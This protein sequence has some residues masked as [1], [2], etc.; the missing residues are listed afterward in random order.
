MEQNKLCNAVKHIARAYLF[1]HIH[2]NL[3]TVDILPD[4]LGYLWIL[5]AIAVIGEEIESVKLLRPL[6]TALAL[7]EWIQWGMNILGLSGYLERMEILKLASTI[8]MVIDIYFHFQLLTNVAELAARYGCSAE[9]RILQMRTARTVI[10]TL[11]M[12]PFPWE[13]NEI[14]YYTYLGI[15]VVQLIVIFWTSKILYDFRHALW[16]VLSSETLPDSLDT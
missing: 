15:A 13:F 14:I 10:S 9:K 11:F 6:G 4:W 8:L 7:W 5:S 16:A 12:L 2:I 3:G 1:I